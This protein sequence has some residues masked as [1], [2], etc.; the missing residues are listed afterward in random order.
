ME[1]D[2]QVLLEEKLG[3]E[4]ELQKLKNTEV[5]SILV[6]ENGRIP[7]KPYYCRTEIKDLFKCFIIRF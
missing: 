1:S 2:F 5:S 3:L 7:K 4:N 6:S